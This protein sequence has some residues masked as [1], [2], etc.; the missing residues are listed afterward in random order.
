MSHKQDRDKTV[1]MDLLK[2]KSDMYDAFIN[3]GSEAKSLSMRRVPKPSIQLYNE[4]MERFVKNHFELQK[5]ID[6]I[7]MKYESLSD[8]VEY[9]N[10]LIP[11]GYQSFASFQKFIDEYYEDVH[12]KIS[13]KLDSMYHDAVLKEAAASRMI[14]TNDL[15]LT[16]QYMSE[17][18]NIVNPSLGNKNVLTEKAENELE[19]SMDSFESLLSDID[20]ELKLYKDI[21]GKYPVETEL[22]REIADFESEFITG[23]HE[24]KKYR[25]KL[26][27]NRGLRFYAGNSV[28]STTSDFG[29]P[30]KGDGTRIT[31]DN[32]GVH[33]GP[34][35]KPPSMSSPYPNYVAMRQASGMIIKSRAQKALDPV[36]PL[37]DSASQYDVAKYYSTMGGGGFF[38]A[39]GGPGYSSDFLSYPQSHDSGA[40]PFRF[41]KQEFPVF[42][43]LAA[44]Y[45]QF[46]VK[47]SQVESQCIGRGSELSLASLLKSHCEGDAKIVLEPFVPS[48]FFYDEMWAA[49]DQ[50]FGEKQKI[51]ESLITEIVQLGNQAVDTKNLRTFLTWMNKI[52]KVR[53]TLVTVTPHW[54][55]QVS[56]EMVRKLA[57]KLSYVAKRRWFEISQSLK[58][59]DPN[60][61]LFNEFVVFLEQERAFVEY[62]AR[63]GLPS[64]TPK[65][66]KKKPKL[67]KCDKKSGDQAVK[68]KEKGHKVREN[69][70]HGR[71]TSS[72]PTTS[73]PQTGRRVGSG[74]E[75][76]GRAC[77]YCDKSGSPHLIKS[78]QAWLMVSPQQK[79]EYLIKSKRCLAC[80]YL[81]NNHKKEKCEQFCKQFGGRHLCKKDSCKHK[82]KRHGRWYACNAS[83]VIKSHYGM[84]KTAI[85][86]INQA[87]IADT[88]LSLTTFSDPGSTGS[89]IM[90]SAARKRRLKCVGK[91]DLTVHTM[92]GGQLTSLSSIYEVP[93]VTK[94]HGTH[95]LYAHSVEGF[96][97]KK[98][99]YLNID[100]LK[101]EFPNY[102]GDYE[103]L[104]YSHQTVELLIGLSDTRLLPTNVLHEG[105]N[106]INL[107]IRSSEI[108]DTVM[109]TYKTP[110]G[111]SHE[112]NSVSVQ[113][114]SE[115]Y[116]VSD[117]IISNFVH[118]QPPIKV[119]PAVSKNCINPKPTVQ[120]KAR[121]NGL[122]VTN[123]RGTS[124][125]YRQQR[126]FKCKPVLR[127]G[128]LVGEPQIRFQSN[129]DVQPCSTGN[130]VDCHECIDK[131]VPTGII[132]DNVVE[133]QP[134]LLSS[135]IS[136]PLSMKCNSVNKRQLPLVEREK[137]VREDSH[138][139]LDP[140]P[141]SLQS[142]VF[143]HTLPYTH[144]SK[145][146]IQLCPF[147]TTFKN[148]KRF[149]SFLYWVEGKLNSSIHLIS[150]PSI[151]Y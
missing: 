25:L 151:S 83:T 113:I 62:E 92:G 54:H 68:N 79:R 73:P 37:D 96:L 4:Y 122:I 134:T 105:L 10:T 55:Y 21:V 120:R 71:S 7:I 110:P 61:S 91:T 72:L 85:F 100:V 90:K 51:I 63:L 31:S 28:P 33:N 20:K 8:E 148:P 121:N 89:F 95:T 58:F 38:G 143:V 98:L 70:L 53:N 124:N 94:N 101:R 65:N 50:V 147:Y 114:E 9:R 5:L 146:L 86:A 47:W 106:E 112:N 36:R 118:H 126:I 116:H 2:A 52:E 1:V 80:A 115:N 76:G 46:K 77:F 56:S 138:L 109:G 97:V 133:C 117:I 135:R 11:T 22:D 137:C 81:L 149:C 15:K 60:I 139:V 150:S 49:L 23:K 145:N 136:N 24:L 43:G 108:G 18:E 12:M 6:K 88:E 75:L 119:L 48:P 34:S 41:K 29:V 17:C 102:I 44:D 128:Y 125:Q 132:S 14:L 140:L 127:S 111:Q 32:F 66:F 67:G 19:G 129:I 27:T 142:M 99:N 39:G 107:Q 59:H 40:L 57:N 26:K 131:N 69:V 123:L 45:Q 93:I 104:Q 64:G 42:S 78:C 144:K 3:A 84:N 103:K 16:K 74:K 141:L 130:T 87:Q 35:H 82:A 13:L 30:N